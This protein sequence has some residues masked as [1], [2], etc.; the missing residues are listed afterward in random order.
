LPPGEYALVEFD[1]KGAMNQLVWDFGV[2]PLAPKN[3]NVVRPNLEQN[4]PILLKKA[5]KKN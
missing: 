3:S 1:K 2:N 5:P 4:G